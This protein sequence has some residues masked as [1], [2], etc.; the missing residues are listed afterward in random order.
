MKG[1][2]IHP[3]LEPIFT[4]F[5]LVEA[6]ARAAGRAAHRARRRPR[7]A[8]L[9]PGPATPLWN[10]LAR[11]AASRV[12][13]YG[14][15]AHLARCLGVPRQRVHEYLVARTACPDA[16]RVLRLL[17]WLRAQPRVSRNT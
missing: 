16:E 6:T 14:A 13:R 15:K 1:P 17:V 7:G 12:T 2:H 10:E 5:D 9:R 8:T 11:F 4:L 3:R